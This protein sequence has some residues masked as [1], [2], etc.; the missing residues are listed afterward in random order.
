[1]NQTLTTTKLAHDM[2]ATYRVIVRCGY[3]KAHARAVVRDYITMHG[4]GPRGY[5]RKNNA[6][7]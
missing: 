1:M 4:F 2:M 3:S 5:Y 6:C 7:K